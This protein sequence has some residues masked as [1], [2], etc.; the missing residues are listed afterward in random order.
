MLAVIVS[1]KRNE[2]SNTT[3]MLRRSESRCTS[4]TS[5]P[6][7]VIAPGVHVVEAR[8]HQ[9]DGRLARPGAADERDRLARRDGEVEVVEHR[10][11][12]RVAERHVVEP[13][14]AVRHVE[15]DR[16]GRVLHERR[17]VE[18]V[19]DPFGAGAG[20]LADGEDRRE[21]PD[22]RRDQQ[23]VRGER[24]ERAEA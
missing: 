19:V 22:R 1:E 23:H 5:T 6:S 18:Q 15:V 8:Q 7:I 21:L 17:R 13:H 3:P 14:L 16:V 9:R 24:E 10:I 12:R 4:R 20:E 2:S 11:G